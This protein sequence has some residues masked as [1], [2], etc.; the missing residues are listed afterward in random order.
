MMCVL[1]GVAIA[2]L[3]L[4]IGFTIWMFYD[5]YKAQKQ[6]DVLL[7]ELMT[8]PR[9]AV[10]KNLARLEVN[11]TMAV[12]KKKAPIKKAVKAVSKKTKK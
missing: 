12:V 7:E 8:D 5:D 2:L 9:W 6:T 4:M 1:A 3:V 10:R 11:E